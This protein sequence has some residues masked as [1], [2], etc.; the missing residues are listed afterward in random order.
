VIDIKILLIKPPHWD[1][2][3]EIE[4]HIPIGLAYLA[5]ACKK[6][7][8]EVKIFDSLAFTEDNRVLS[9]NELSENQ[10][11]KVKNHPGWKD[12]VHL[13]AS[14]ERIEQYIL[15]YKPDIV[16]VSMMFSPYYETAYKVVDIVRNTL[17][18]SKIIAGGA[19]ATVEYKHVLENTSVDYVLLGEGEKTLPALLSCIEK[20]KV[21]YEIDG[22]AFKTDGN[23]ENNI[24][25]NEKKELI[26]NLD[27]IDYPEVECLDLDKYDRR[28]TLITSR[29]CPFNCAFCT[30]HSISGNKFRFRK[31]QNVVDEIEWY[32]KRFN[33]RK[34]NIEDDNM[35]Y[36]MERTKEILSM[37][38]D[39]KLDIEIFLPNGM[40]VI[41]MTEDIAKTMVRAGV[42]DVFFGLETTSND[43]LK[44]MEKG[45]TSLSQVRDI[46]G[47][48]NNF[49]I[50]AE[51]SLIIG[52]PD[53]TLSEIIM[54]ISTL[55]KNELYFGVPNP[56]YPVNG[57]KLQKKCIKEGI[58]KESTDFSWYS[59]YNFP[60]MTQEFTREDIFVIW[61]ACMGIGLC[62][63]IIQGLQNDFDKNINRF[64][65]IIN[66]SS[67]GQFITINGKNYYK[68]S[69]G[70]TFSE[71]MK[72]NPLNANGN[73]YIDRFNGSIICTLAY[74]YTGIPYKYTQ[75]KS[76]LAGDEQVEFL[77][78]D[79]KDN[80]NKALE[81][82]RIELTKCI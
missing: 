39:K 59:E 73:K 30:V 80:R 49:N 43:K 26:Y 79:D 4:R 48:F 55:I 31:A 81:L 6:Y 51:T 78:E 75:T 11:N 5:S 44:Q 29:G 28:T 9:F 46:L 60:V 61:C 62:S 10:T 27:E 15:E 58:I 56:F 74:L 71:L 66:S 32:I 2:Y 68:P 3:H 34:F 42:K 72:I 22:I 67:I 24:Y 19:H 76:I 36:D 20:D 14:F 18:H 45:F 37:I 63:S 33:I 82:L 47:W 53:Q 38:I 8:H 52:L 21:P 65:K 41:N 57:S 17:P 69:K 70:T 1:F 54:D 40:T 13:G 77:I 35:S 7:N 25:L 12:V 16:G 23:V 50:K 64:M